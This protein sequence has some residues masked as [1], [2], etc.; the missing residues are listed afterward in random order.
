MQRKVSTNFQNYSKQKN[1]ET[2]LVRSSF[3]IG[4]SEFFRS[5]LVTDD[6]NNMA[7]QQY[8][9]IFLALL[10]DK[11]IFDNFITRVN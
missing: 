10:A 6:K 2:F 9:S 11:V 4:V 1:S 5:L 8:T 3:Q 7:A